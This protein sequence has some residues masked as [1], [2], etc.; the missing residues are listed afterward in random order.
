MSTPIPTGAQLDEAQAFLAAY[1]QVQAIDVVLSDLH[2]IGRGKIIRRHELE[3]LYTAGRGMPG[4]LFAQGIDGVDVTDALAQHA[5]DG[6]DSRCWPVPGSLGFMP[7]TGRGVVLVQMFGADG[8]S[9]HSDPRGAMMAQVARAQ[10]LGWQ[11]M[12]AMELEFYL[13]D[14]GHDGQ[15]APLSPRA[16]LTGRRLA[17]NNCMSVDE[18]DE[19][20]P[21]FDDVY[22]G[23]RALGLP[24]E[25]VI[26][27]Y[28]QGQ[29]EL[30]LQYRAL[31][32]AADDIV[33]AK[34]LLRANARRHGFE[35]CF[36]PKPFGA[37]SGSGMHLH[38]SLADAAGQNLF[39][40]PLE[41]GLAPMLLAAIGGVRTSMGDSMLVLAPGLNSW[42]RFANTVYSPATNSWA[43]E[44]RGVALRV[45]GGQGRSRHFEHRVAGVDANP[46]LCAAITLGAALDGITDGLQPGTPGLQ[47]AA[48][49]PPLPDHWQAA[50]AQFERAP[51]MARL[52]GPELH[53]GFAALKTAEAAQ[54]AA[55]VTDA[56]WQLYG[57]RV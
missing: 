19:M 20:A 11:P 29:F 6:G 36:M 22:A 42:R 15:G 33:L 39:A 14:R 43:V 44:D 47:G 35:A 57:F 8:A 46:Y 38:L 45:P 26:S 50:I 24:L 21:F 56:E 30:T 31:D 2:G 49:L 40:D 10:A 13:T 4:T 27:E 9:Y 5:A 17:G 23:A 16:P 41:G 53:A 54:M 3:G 32:R 55:T 18:L 37:R 7:A 51:S 48:D 34:R 25:T 28:A 52:L 12:G 1:P